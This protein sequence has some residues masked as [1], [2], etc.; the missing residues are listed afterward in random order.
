MQIRAFEKYIPNDL[1]SRQH[2]RGWLAERNLPGMGG[3][4]RPI[5]INTYHFAGFNPLII[6]DPLGEDDIVFVKS[7]DSEYSRFESK[8]LVYDDKTLNAINLG[9]LKAWGFIKQLFGGGLNEKDVKF[10]I[11]EPKNFGNTKGEFKNFSTLPDDPTTQGTIAAEMIYD[12]HRETLSNGL[13]GLQLSS[14][15]GEG[16][17]PQ[18]PK[19]NG[20]VN[21][22]HPTRNPYAVEGAFV[23]GARI[24]VPNSPNYEA[25]SRGCIT[26]YGFSRGLLRVLDASPTGHTGRVVIFR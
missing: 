18:D 20:G 1:D 17:V 8:A 15:I 2:K 6:V 5:K 23:H 22:A 7:S 13:P 24:G 26:G 12:Y 21:P 4:F 9:L 16:V 10:I 25:G 19:F 14:S 11:G 3:V